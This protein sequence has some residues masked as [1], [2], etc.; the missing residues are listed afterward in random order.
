MNI[1]DP[2]AHMV[3]RTTDDYE[4]MALAGVRAVV[5]PSFWLGQPRTQAGSF[6]DY[7]DSIIEWEAQR[8]AN[9]GIQHFCCIA[10]NPRE[11]NNRKLAEEVL[12]QLER[13]LDRPGVVAV[14]EIGFDLVT[15][16]EEHAI[17]RQVEM[18]QKHRL[19]IL[20]HTPHRNK[21]KG[22]E[23]NLKIL[24]DMGVDRNVVLIDHNTEETIAMVKESGYWAGHT[25]YPMTKLSP[26]R[27]ANILEEFGTE[28]M[29]VNSSCDW[30]PSDPLSVPRTV[31][32]MRR[33]GF[34][35]ADIRK[36]VWENPIAF[37]AQ[38]GR[39]NIEGSS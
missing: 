5:E 7:F 18:A 2:H 20:V 9:H 10:L 17:R 30:G 21:E 29:L 32:E 27:A 11:A 38:S 8:A 28:K 6:F 19:P 13:Y 14:G 37:F 4:K 22:T 36:V 35:E 33:R 26:E 34:S 12:A 39:M 25:V 1:L 24:A 31:H 15:D 16:A 23:R 3:S